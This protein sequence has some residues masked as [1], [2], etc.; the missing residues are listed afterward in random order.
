MELNLVNVIH[1]I[2]QSLKYPCLVVLL[3]LFAVSIWQFGGFLIEA[4]GRRRI[5]KYIGIDDFFEIISKTENMEKAITKIEFEKKQKNGLLELLKKSRTDV[6]E[7]RIFATEIL[8]RKENEFIKILS[9]TDLV[10]TLGPM[11][12]LLGTLIPLGP[13]IVALG[14]GDTELLSKSLSIAFDTTVIGVI[15]A[16]IA[17][18]ISHSRKKWYEEDMIKYELLMD[19]LLTKLVKEEKNV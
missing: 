10:S 19:C 15:S 8:A 17:F 5:K 18:I 9:V 14:S 3:I 11:F 12:G 1:W 7:L 4:T 16:G 13:G 6:D 2:S